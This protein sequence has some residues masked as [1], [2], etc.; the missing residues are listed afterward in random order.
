MR[1]SES[2]SS[3]YAVRGHVVLRR[4]TRAA[5]STTY[6]SDH[7]NFATSYSSRCA[8]LTRSHDLHSASSIEFDANPNLLEEVPRGDGG[9]TSCSS[10]ALLARG[11]LH[12]TGDFRGFQSPPRR[13]TPNDAART[14]FG[15]TALV[16]A[17]NTPPQPF[18]LPVPG[19]PEDL[20]A[21]A[22][23]AAWNDVRTRSAVGRHAARSWHP[24][25]WGGPALVVAVV[26]IALA[27][28]LSGTETW[29]AA[30]LGV[31]A[32]VLA[33]LGIFRWQRGLT[34]D[35]R[36]RDVLKSESWLPR[37]VHFCESPLGGMTVEVAATDL[38]PARHGHLGPAE[39][40]HFAPTLPPDGTYLV[41]D[42]PVGDAVLSNSTRTE[43]VLL[44][45]PEP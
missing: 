32:L 2:P 25:R 20:E 21:L 29:V 16:D 9:P 14:F 39:H 24:L 12:H 11:D 5:F 27:L 3:P 34:R 6:T 7:K 13:R 30:L 1:F 37:Q 10:G 44:A 45:H 17:R 35:R 18:N 42:D 36:L 41:A 31:A 38:L 28:S 8:E 19:S 43:L 40:H 33:S 26:A 15:D 22:N 4:T 23:R